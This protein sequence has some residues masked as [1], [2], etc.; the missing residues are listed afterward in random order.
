MTNKYN[1][2]RETICPQCGKDSSKCDCDTK[3]EGSYKP[4]GL[5]DE[6]VLVMKRHTD[7]G[8]DKND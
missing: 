3:P 6:K 5:I 7:E 4:I 2:N 8:E 1:P